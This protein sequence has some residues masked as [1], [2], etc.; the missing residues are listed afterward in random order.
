MENMVGERG[1]AK[2]GFKPVFVFG[3]QPQIGPADRPKG[4]AEPLSNL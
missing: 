3:L 1:L 2:T 4:P